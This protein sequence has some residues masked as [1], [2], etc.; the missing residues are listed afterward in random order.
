MLNVLVEYIS[1]VMQNVLVEMYQ[2]SNA[3]YIIRN[4]LKIYQQKCSSRG[5]M[6][7]QYAEEIYQQNVL[8]SEKM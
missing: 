8:Y 7:E 4:V 5:I 3:N 6:E 1:K 2:Y